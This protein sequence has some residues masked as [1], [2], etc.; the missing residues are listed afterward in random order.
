M[1][2]VIAIIF[3]A[4]AAFGQKVIPN[5]PDVEYAI[6]SGQSQKLDIY[7][8][9]TGTKPYPVVV[10][11]HGGGWSGGD[12]NSAGTAVNWLRPEGFAIVSINYRLS[13]IAQY[14]A[15]INDCKGAVR[16]IKAHSATYD[17]DTNHIGVWGSSAGGHLVALMGTSGDIGVHTIDTVSMDLEGTSG[18]NLE[19]SSR[20]QAVCD[21]YGPTDFLEIWKYPSGL[22]HDA[23]NSPESLLLG[24]PMLTVPERC[25][26][27]NPITF[28]TPDDPPM[29]IMHGTK[30]NTVPFNQ[31]ELLDSALRPVYEPLEKEVLFYPIVDAGHGGGGFNAD[32][33][34]QRVVAFFNKHLKEGSADVVHTEVQSDVNFS[35]SHSSVTVSSKDVLDRVEIVDLMGRIQYYTKPNSREL[36]ISTT[37]FAGG[38]Y[39]LITY[40]KDQMFAFKFKI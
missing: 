19:H 18:G 24:S 36:N 22:D 31:S 14:P 3:A 2:V 8:P 11:V 10:W 6:V 9:T 7:L 34:R 35:A 23:P 17:F 15:Q 20:I 27:A 13:G 4:S 30:D 37:H 26:L 21:W 16:W 33:T 32:S 12:K 40:Y 29:L 38:T 28:I 1:K 5:V 25:M 39:F